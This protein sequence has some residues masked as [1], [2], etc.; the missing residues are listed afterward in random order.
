M[1]QFTLDGPKTW[2]PR[3]LGLLIALLLAVSACGEATPTPV[4]PTATVAPATATVAV[5][6]AT[7]T[8]AVPP[9][10]TVPAAT[11]TLATPPTPT[12]GP[13]MFTN[14]VINRDYPDPDALKVGDTYYAYAT[15]AGSMNVQAAKSTDLVHWT[16]LH[17]ALP[18]LPK[19]AEGGNTWAPEVT[20]SADGKTYVMYVAA[21]RANQ[22]LQCIGAATSDRP[23]G[24]F[25]SATDEPFI[26]QTDQGGDIDP[27]S[28]VDEDGTRYVLW[29]NDGN[30]FGGSTWLYIQKVSAD[31]LT[32]EGEPTQ[33]IRQDQTWEGVVIEAPTLWKHN[34]KYY[35]FYSANDYATLKYAVGYAQADT[36]L[37]PYTKAPDPFLAT[38]LQRPPILGPGGQD[39]VLD[40]KGNTWMLF[41]AW[42]PTVTFRTL[43]I[44]PLTWEGDKPVVKATRQPESVP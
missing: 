43:N 42:D 3:V 37:G 30:C 24:I 22:G 17:D 25:K 31:G 36:I 33:L 1:K 39:I 35:L 40:A 2:P 16:L 29:K 9:T 34:G 18:A 28:F 38:S 10:D 7:P 4:P 11:P 26:C 41:H 19:W 23:D 12:L 21:R 20:T 32:L 14:P 5:S 27:S 6:A 13:G 8:V 44:A 15:N